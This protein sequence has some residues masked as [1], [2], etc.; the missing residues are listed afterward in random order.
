[1]KQMFKSAAFA[2]ALVVLAQSARAQAPAPKELLFLAEDV[3]AG[4]NYDGPSAAIGTTQTGYL[5]MMEPLLYYPY[6]PTE[7][8]VRT[9]DFSKHDGR[10]AESWSFDAPSLTWT[11]HLRHGVKS[12]SGNEFSADDVIYT[13]ARA[14]SVS[15]TAPVSW[16]LASVAGI[17]G[18]TRDVFKPGADKSLGDGVEKVDD[19]TVK[20][21]QSAAN[22]LFLTAM[23]IYATYPFDSKEMKAHATEADPWSHNYVNTTNVPSFGPY[24][25]ESW[26]R[27]DQF[28]LRANPNYYRG[29]PP[30]DRVIMKKVPQS[31]NRVLTLR[32]GKA[33][34]TQRLTTREFTSLSKAPGVTVAGIY[35]N[36]TLFLLLNFKTPPFDNPKVRQAVAYALPYKQI[37]SIGYSGS[38]RHWGAQFPHIFVGFEQPDVSYDTDVVKAKQLLAEAG[39][40]GGVGLEKYADSFKLAFTAERESTLGPIAT[41]IQSALKDL[42]FPIELDPMPQTQLGDRRLV[43]K[44]LPMSLADVEKS[45]GPDVT[46]TTMMFFVSTGNGGISNWSNYSNPEIDRLFVAARNEPDDAKQLAMLKTI[47]DTLERDLAWVP[48]VETE[49]QWAFRSSLKG[50]TWHPDNSVRFDDLSWAP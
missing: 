29:A 10:L 32:A 27:D 3:P 26:V 25:L 37:A 2:A 39:Y 34:L 36:E 30:I 44:D 19:Y 42:G 35:G 8:G 43:K 16:F 31:A 41:V 45:V 13:F 5:N 20:I 14:K 28:V 38:A 11:L 6:G 21:R 4:L 46:Y 18:F 33:D 49:T 50:I 48:I 22:R 47:Q 12:C 40:P 17:K 24:C 7:G 9:L 23:S 1:M 15:G